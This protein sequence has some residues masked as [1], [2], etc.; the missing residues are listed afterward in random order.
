MYL[1]TPL[2]KFLK[3]LEI[4]NFQG[5]C[6]HITLYQIISVYDNLAQNWRN[7]FQPHMELDTLTDNTRLGTSKPGAI[8]FSIEFYSVHNES[9]H[10]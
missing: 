2:R 3:A 5:F 7:E 9:N 10:R 8:L 6:S 1:T 4:L